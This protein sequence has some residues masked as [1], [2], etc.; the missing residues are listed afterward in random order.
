M[1]MRVPNRRLPL[2]LLCL[3]TAGLLSSCGGG[4]DFS[5]DPEVPDGYK[6]YDADG[7]SF[8]YP[9]DWQ[10]AERTDQEGAP[11]V[12]ITPPEKSKTPYGLISV[13]VSPKAG[14]RFDS[15]VDQSRIAV[16]DVNNGKIDSDESVDIPGAKKALRSTATVPAD[17]G[18][19]PVEVKSDNLDLV[20]DNGDVVNLTVAAPQRDG[21]DFDPAAVVDS[22]RLKD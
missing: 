10:V 11:V 18:S 17:Q 20:R 21:Q 6:T 7:I 9:G 3:L 8:A 13:L 19:D 16:R 4:N 22:F 5:G 2:M 15:L 14:D 1:M 12:E